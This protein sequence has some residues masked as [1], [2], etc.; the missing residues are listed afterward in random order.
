MKS[1][2]EI[3]KAG[4]EAKIHELLLN[5]DLDVDALDGDGFGALHIAAKDGNAK[6]VEELLAA[7]ASVALRCKSS[8]FAVQ[9]GTPLHFAALGGSIAAMELLLEAGADIDARCF[10]VAVNSTS[11]IQRVPFE[12]TTPLA[13]AVLESQEPIALKLLAAGA[14]STSNK[15]ETS[16]LHAAATS[17]LYN[18][19]KVMLENG[20]DIHAENETQHCTCLHIAASQ[21]NMEI[22]NLLLEYGADINSS[23]RYGR[24]PL[25]YAVIS[26]Q[27]EVFELF[28]ALGADPF[29]RSTLSVPFGESTS[30][31]NILHLAAMGD[32]LRI[33]Q[34]GLDLG[35]DIQAVDGS[36]RNVLHLAMM[37]KHGDKVLRYILSL[38]QIDINATFDMY[39][40]GAWWLRGADRDMVAG[41]AAIHIACEIALEKVPLL[42]NAGADVTLRNFGRFTPLHFLCFVEKEAW[43]EKREA[44]KAAFRLLIAKGVDINAASVTGLTP[45]L[46][47][48]WSGN[49][50][51]VSLLITAGADMH[52]ASTLP[53]PDDWFYDV[54]ST[55]LHF[56]A[57][58]GEIFFEI[59]SILKAAGNVDVNVTDS[60]GN[61]PLHVLVCSRRDTKLLALLHTMHYGFCSD[62]GRQTRLGYVEKLI[63][64]GA[65]VCIKNN[66]GH[67]PLQHLQCCITNGGYYQD[68]NEDFAKSGEVIFPLIVALVAG[69]D[70]SWDA[71]PY[72]CPGLERALVPLWNKKPNELRRLRSWLDNELQE[73]IQNIL[74]ALHHGKLW[75][76]EIRMLIFEK[77]FD[78]K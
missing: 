67:T 16:I 76:D 40:P 59:L 60:E 3:A 61:T 33:F 74:R 28:L 49:T 27:E 9:G 41:S 62:L 39:E 22:L 42:I 1:L 64:A 53:K 25:V 58:S 13:V 51:A 18:V 75:P 63:K 70:C 8:K 2:H 69:G 20:A 15:S 57:M 44:Y 73:R 17:G 43:E 24:T 14:N 29:V 31:L 23:D 47:A 72:P 12:I 46:C 55:P 48:Y 34:R 45:L 4:I 37:S 7:G 21:G 35:I 68:L 19:L 38:E 30:D 26:G 54:G 65:D 52:M 66:E 71:V 10:W 11:L 56:A 5:P 78:G 6:M 32:H 77:V 50:D 36:E